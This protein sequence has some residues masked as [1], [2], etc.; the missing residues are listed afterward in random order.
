MTKKQKAL[1][2]IRLLKERYP[3][4]ACSLTYVVPHELLIATRLAA[5]CTDAR[6]NTV[7]P[8]LFG[9]YPSIDA[10]AGADVA[11]IEEI[12]RPCGF[13]KTK[14]KDIVGM[15]TMLRDDFGGVVPDTLEEL[16]KLP[17]IGRKTA[18][19]VVGDIYGKPAIVCDTHCIRLTNRLGLT[20][21]K[22]P[23]KTEFELM[24]LLPPEESNNFCH[25]LVMFGRDVCR[26]R[27]PQC[28][29]CELEPLCVSKG[30]Q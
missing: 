26:A 23:K 9:K 25:R 19:L 21:T 2:A 16:L 20:T 14:A 10:L 7:T 17:G 8:T 12:I 11:D 6:V 18:N 15:C 24:P 29:A 13:F 30:K 1:E 28:A 5:Q 3:D 4:A 22:D 27:S